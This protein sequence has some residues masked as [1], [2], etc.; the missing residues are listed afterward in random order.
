[1]HSYYLY[2]IRYDEEATGISRDDFVAA[3]NAEGVPLKGLQSPSISSRFS[4]A[5]RSA[6][7]FPSPTR[8]IQE[9]FHE[10]VSPVTERC[11]KSCSSPTSATGHRTG[12]H[13]VAEAFAVRQS[14]RGATVTV[15]P[16]GSGRGDRLARLSNHSRFRGL[17]Y[18]IRCCMPETQEGI[19]FDE[20][21]ICQACQSSEHKI[22]TIAARERELRRIRRGQ[23]QSRRQLR[24]YGS[25]QRREGQHLP[26]PRWSRST[27]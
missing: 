22:H 6:N 13:D 18:C 10:R 8:A 17:R 5:S 14:R 26:A 15:R 11:T 23:G 27:A 21:G 7:G 2:A 9:R 20:M 24:P 12:R 25:H 19:K 4:A 16:R 1:V 3:V